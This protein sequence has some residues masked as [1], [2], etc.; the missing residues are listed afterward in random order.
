MR[1][2]SIARKLAPEEMQAVATSYG[3]HGGD[4]QQAIDEHCSQPRDGPPLRR[5]GFLQ[6]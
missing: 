5:E 6:D 4:W 1:T 3:S 2:R